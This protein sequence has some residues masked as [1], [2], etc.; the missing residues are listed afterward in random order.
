MR[1]KDNGLVYGGQITNNLLINTKG[2]H[3]YSGNVCIEWLY[4]VLYMM[5]TMYTL[6]VTY[7]HIGHFNQYGGLTMP[8]IYC[9]ADE[10][11][12]KE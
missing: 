10:F 1:N 5:D 6:V 11:V 7:I 8:F 9:A 2:V 4:C 12:I 3:I